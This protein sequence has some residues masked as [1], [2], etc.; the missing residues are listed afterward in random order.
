MKSQEEI[1]KIP[2]VVL[3]FWHDDWFGEEHKTRVFP[4]RLH[5]KVKEQIRFGAYNTSATVK[6]PFPIFTDSEDLEIKLEKG[7]ITD[8]H[9]VKMPDICT[10]KV[11]K[12]L[13]FFY[14]VTANNDLAQGYSSPS[15]IIED[16]G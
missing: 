8:P 16:E 2:K 14:E 5:V 9:T 11:I 4:G 10:E 12:N 7:K 13:E 3:I 1:P 15:M 6:L